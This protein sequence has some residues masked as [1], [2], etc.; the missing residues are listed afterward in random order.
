MP[1]FLEEEVEHVFSASE[2]ESGGD[3][4]S[5]Q[6][7]FV[8]FSQFDDQ[9]LRSAML[10][11]ILTTQHTVVSNDMKSTRR[12]LGYSLL[13]SLVRL[14][15]SLIRLLRTARFARALRCAHLIASSLIPS[16]RC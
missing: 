3:D 9:L 14:H 4:V 6:F 13:R 1:G 10:L 15:R 12:V 5:R 11:E 2:D 7:V 16:L 8:G